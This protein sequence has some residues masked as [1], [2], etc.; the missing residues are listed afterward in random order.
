MYVVLNHKGIKQNGNAF[1]FIDKLCHCYAESNILCFIIVY[2]SRFPSF[3]IPSQE[4]NSSSA[5]A[6][7]WSDICES[8]FQPLHQRM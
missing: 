7:V 1:A 8:I 5:F 4:N 3:F 2:D 6:S